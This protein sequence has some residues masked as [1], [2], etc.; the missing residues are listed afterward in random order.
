M[1]FW[2]AILRSGSGREP[3]DFTLPC[4]DGTTYSFDRE[5]RSTRHVVLVF[6]RGHW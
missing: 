1:S 6:Y 2:R 3:F 4:D 5:R